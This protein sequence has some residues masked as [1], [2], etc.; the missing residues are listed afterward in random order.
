[1][2]VR[3]LFWLC[4]AACVAF[5]S[6]SVARPACHLAWVWVHDLEGREPLPDDVVDDA[7][8]LNRTAV[9]EVWSI[10]EEPHAAEAQLAALLARARETNTKVSI[11][12]A[13]HSMGGHTISPGG[14]FVDM[15]PFDAMRFDPQRRI[16]HVGA[17]AT[18][19]RIIPFL[20]ARGLSVGV[21]QS[22]NSFSVGGSI[23]VNCHGWV[24]GQPPICSTVEAL[25]IMT[26][27]GA[28]HRCSREENS[29]LFSLAL[30]GYGLF[31]VILDVELRVVPNACY[32]SDQVVVPFADAVPLL[33]EAVRGVPDVAMFY[34]RLDVTPDSLFDEAILYYLRPAAGEAIPALEPNSISGFR[35][36]VL[37]GAAAND[38]G[39]D[40]RWSAETLL[41]GRLGPAHFSRNQLLNEGVEI[42]ENRKA[43]RTDILH[44]YFVPAAGVRQFLADVRAVLQRLR[45][46]LLNVTLRCVRE[47]RD[48]F[49]RFAD[50]D[51]LAV[52]ML[53]EQERNDV[54]EQQMVELTRALVDAAL[55]AGGRHYLPY[56]LHPTP[57]QFRAAYPQADEFF[58]KKRTFDP[59]E[60]FDN[61]FYAAYARPPRGR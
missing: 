17:G 57:E 55:A 50:Q 40:L 21:V 10:P 44:E 37:R 35:R 28:V 3:S 23:S 39:K 27:D 16:L 13:R 25:R 22:N 4:V 30:G 36:L 2:S 19:A 14:I 47:D 58:V 51:M 12:G 54:A 56:R 42:F 8:R 53:F 29:E 24:Y 31:G 45:P 49:L 60:L 9:A 48:T 33:E 6:W 15:R 5:G 32:W 52:V 38:Y 20:D 7:S 26:A 46:N 61:R 43:D 11:G 41:Q 1:M 59:G 18:W 34:A